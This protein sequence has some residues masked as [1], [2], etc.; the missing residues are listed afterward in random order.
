MEPYSIIESRY[1]LIYKLL[2]LKTLRPVK[3]FIGKSLIKIPVTLDPHL[4]NTATESNE[5]TEDSDIDDINDNTIKSQVD[6]AKQ[7]KTSTQRNANKD[8]TNAQWYE[9]T[10]L[11][12]T[13][14]LSGKRQCLV[15]WKDN[16]PPSWEYEN[17]VSEAL[18]AAFHTA[19]ARKKRH[20]RQY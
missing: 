2:D 15:Q 6:Q 13:R 14:S 11:L 5:D 3:S 7:T 16:S 10:K 19:K 12:K 18:K 8:K 20:K 4:D 1:N 17:D 9:A